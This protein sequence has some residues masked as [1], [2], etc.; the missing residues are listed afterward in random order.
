MK[1]NYYY[2]KRYNNLNL[3]F[4]AHEDM[5]NS[6]LKNSPTSNYNFEFS[7]E[8]IINEIKDI[9]VKI[10]NLSKQTNNYLKKIRINSII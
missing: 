3:D 7:L 8:N 2:N 9:S 6:N 1:Q 10:S 4:E 5:N